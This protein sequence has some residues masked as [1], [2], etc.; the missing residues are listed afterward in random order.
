MTYSIY[1]RET[2]KRLA[3][4]GLREAEVL[5]HLCWQRGVFP[6]KVVVSDATGLEYARREKSLVPVEVNHGTS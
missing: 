4:P 6:L 1:D 3:G 2:E 5:A